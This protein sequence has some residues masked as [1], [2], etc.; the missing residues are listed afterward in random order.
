MLPV[1]PNR[2]SSEQFPTTHWSRVASAGAPDTPGAREA[3]A[4]LCAAYWYPLYAYIRRRGYTPEKAGDLTQDFFA[5]LLEEG[6]LAKAEPGR[7]RFRA[8][9]RAVCSH[10]LA[11]QVRREHTQ[12][13]GGGRIGFSMD[14]EEAEGRYARELSH[15]DTPERIFD[16]AWALTLLGRVFE[17]LRREHQARGMETFQV[18]QVTLTEGPGGVP[19]AT[20]AERLGISEGAV[21][22][23]AH[24]LRRRYGELL[25][26]EIATTVD[27]PDEVDGEIRALFTALES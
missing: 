27:D 26:R 14:A 4:T 13:R 8:F 20:L 7:G 2:P 9:L 12:K 18:L 16:R 15:D 24:R 23:A 21:R 10:Y 22:V 1:P 17:Q 5:Y 19:Y 3:L 25:R 6:L 11:K